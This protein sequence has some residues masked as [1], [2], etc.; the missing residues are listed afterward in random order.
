MYSDADSFVRCLIKVP[1]SLQIEPLSEE[2]RKACFTGNTLDIERTS[3]VFAARLAGSD[4]YDLSGTSLELSELPLK[5][6]VSRVSNKRI[7]TSNKPIDCTW[8]SDVV[9]M[10]NGDP[11]QNYI[12]TQLSVS[13]D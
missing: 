10:G 3:N 13:V 7:D 11:H 6:N 8:F 4:E 5:S 12:H 1:N 2:N 9:R